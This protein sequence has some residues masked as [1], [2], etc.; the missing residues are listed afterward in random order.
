MAHPNANTWNSPTVEGLGQHVENLVFQNL[1]QK[2]NWKDTTIVLFDEGFKEGAIKSNAFALTELAAKTPEGKWE[3]AVFQE[4]AFAAIVPHLQTHNDLENR[5]FGHGD[6]P[7]VILT[8]EGKFHPDTV[9]VWTAPLR[10]EMNAFNDIVEQQRREARKV[11][12]FRQAMNEHRRE[13]SKIYE[14]MNKANRSPQQ[15]L[16]ALGN[17]EGPL[18]KRQRLFQQENLV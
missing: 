8:A 18:A 10:A 1:A 17:L 3:D 13:E 6:G 7:N 16:D 4:P 12:L 9:S 5:I 2:S 11:A 14:Q 15:T